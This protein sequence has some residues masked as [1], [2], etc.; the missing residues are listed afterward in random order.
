[1][2]GRGHGTCNRREAGLSR[3]ECTM[4]SRRGS[5]PGRL[6]GPRT[7]FCS[8]SAL[9][10]LDGQLDSFDALMGTDKQSKTGTCHRGSAEGLGCA[11]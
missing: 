9:A 5:S 4:T 8:R 6:H 10:E 1:V 3:K 2:R 11:L 7:K